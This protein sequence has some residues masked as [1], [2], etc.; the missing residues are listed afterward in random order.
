CPIPTRHKWRRDA[1]DLR[2]VPAD[3]QASSFV[4]SQCIH[5]G[6]AAQTCAARHG[7]S[8]TL[9]ALSRPANNV[10]REP[11]WRVHDEPST[12]IHVTVR[13]DS[14]GGYRAPLRGI[15]IRCVPDVTHALTERPP[16]GAVPGREVKKHRR[17]GNV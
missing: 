16:I 5:R 7:N 3:E 12:D 1:V 9:P 17:V 13:R 10:G 11:S 2:K 4:K 14:N 15:A 8:E 6:L